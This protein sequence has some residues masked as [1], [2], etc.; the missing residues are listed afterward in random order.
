MVVR[1][2]LL[3]YQPPPLPSNPLG[4]IY[5]KSSKNYL[6]YQRIPKIPKNSKNT[7]KFKKNYLECSTSLSRAKNPFNFVK[8]WSSWKSS[9]IFVRI[10]NFSD[11][12]K[13][14]SWACSTMGRK[15]LDS[16][17]SDIR[18]FCFSVKIS[19]SFRRLFWLFVRIKSESAST[20]IDDRISI[21]SESRFASDFFE[22]NS[23]KS[24]QI[25]TNSSRTEMFEFVEKDR[26]KIWRWD[27]RWSW[28][29]PI[30]FWKHKKD[31]IVKEAFN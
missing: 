18:T 14:S 21:N 8:S 29:L 6:E 31:K 9:K 1:V 15:R 26:P 25:R 24:E 19:K 23:T 16:S 10:D 20:D 2:V 11:K 7:K 4:F 30:H 12:L 17:L 27:I 13:I 5:K 22:Q 3:F 28:A